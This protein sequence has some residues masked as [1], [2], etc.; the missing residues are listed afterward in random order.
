MPDLEVNEDLKGWQVIICYKLLT[1]K[2]N[3]K[4]KIVGY[5]E[6]ERTARAIAN[7]GGTWGDKGQVKEVRILTQ[8]GKTGFILQEKPIDLSAQEVLIENTRQRILDQLDLDPDER[9]ILGLKPKK[10]V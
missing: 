2:A 4:W 9:I 8:D 10:E 6:D 1:Q 5:I 3:G 7:K